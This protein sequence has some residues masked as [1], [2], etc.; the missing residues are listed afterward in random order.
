[1]TP[2]SLQVLPLCQ[3][4][5]LYSTDDEISPISCLISHKL[6]LYKTKCLIFPLSMLLPTTLDFPSLLMV[7]FQLPSP[8]ILELHLTPLFLSH[9]RHSFHV[10]ENLVFTLEIYTRLLQNNSAFVGVGRRW[11]E[12][13]KWN[14]FAHVLV[15][16]EAEWWVHGGLLYYTIICTLCMSEIFHNTM[17]LVALPLNSAI[18]FL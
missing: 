13:F 3:T 16:V 14:R 10:S 18:P 9:T 2:K 15:M 17:F 12:G 11:G 6:N 7:D 5:F 4:K 8:T 1:M